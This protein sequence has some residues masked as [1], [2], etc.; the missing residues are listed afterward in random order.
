MGMLCVTL[1]GD[2]YGMLSRG[3]VWDADHAAGHAGE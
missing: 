2:G 3:G 1:S